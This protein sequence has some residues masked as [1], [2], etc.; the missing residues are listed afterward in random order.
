[1][2]LSSAYTQASYQDTKYQQKY[3]RETKKLWK[4]KLL[5]FIS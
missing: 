1:M 4:V 2:K 3:Q 5:Y